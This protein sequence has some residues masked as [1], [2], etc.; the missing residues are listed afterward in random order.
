MCRAFYEVV[1]YFENLQSL[2]WLRRSSIGCGL[3]SLLLAAPIPVNSLT[4]SH[5]FFV[6]NITHWCIGTEIYML[7]R[8]SKNV[9]RLHH[10]CLSAGRISFSWSCK[11]SKFSFPFDLYTFLL[12]APNNDEENWYT[13]QSHSSSSSLW[14]Q[15]KWPQS[16]QCNNFFTSI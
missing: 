16:K 14:Q 7:E 8:H 13:R 15:N 12:I 11:F 3:F 5:L 6:R 9:R 1:S 10:C 4:R 2:S